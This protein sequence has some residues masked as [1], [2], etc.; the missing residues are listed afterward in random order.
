[1]EAQDPERQEGFGT[2]TDSSAAGIGEAHPI[3][4][5]VYDCIRTAEGE[6]FW[7]QASRV[8]WLAEA[9]VSARSH[10][11]GNLVSLKGASG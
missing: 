7:L 11:I 5:L 2:V 9:L 1:M 8:G 10:A 3:L 4:I 6:S